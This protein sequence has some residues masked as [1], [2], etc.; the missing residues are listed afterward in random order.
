M[1]QNDWS[2]AVQAVK[3]THWMEA[4]ARPCLGREGPCRRLIACCM[5]AILASAVLATTLE[6]KKSCSASFPAVQAAGK[7]DVASNAYR[8]NNKPFRAPRLAYLQVQCCTCTCDFAAVPA[9]CG[10]CLLGT[11]HAVTAAVP[12]C[13]RC[14]RFPC[15]P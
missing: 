6:R 14:P 7:P 1:L 13:S 4:Q 11:M 5:H 15:V 12:A 2:F 3:Y 10:C 9:A 8:D